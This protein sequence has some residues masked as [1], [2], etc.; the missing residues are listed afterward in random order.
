M[1][2]LLVPC[3]PKPIVCFSISLILP[4]ICRTWAF[5]STTSWCSMSNQ[6]NLVDNGKSN[7]ILHFKDLGGLI[8]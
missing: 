2:A 5:I 1:I 6:N 4:A 7:M 3:F 8:C